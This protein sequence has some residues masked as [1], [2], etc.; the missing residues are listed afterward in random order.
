M[1]RH[2]WKHLPAAVRDAITARLGSLD[3]VDHATAGS[4]GDF[5]ATLDTSTAGRVFCKGA[6]LDTDR[7]GF[8]RNEIRL[9]RHLPADLVPRLRWH[10]EAAGWLIAVFD[11]APGVSVNL[12]PGSPDLP[13]IADALTR[14][15]TVLTPCPPVTIQPATARW[16]RLI[17]PALVD[18]DTLLHTDMTHNNFLICDGR[19]QVVDWSMPCRGAVWLDTARMLVRLI[20]AGHAPAQAESWAARLQAWSSATPEAVDAFA[21]ALAKLSRRLQDNS[22][23]APHLAEMAMA[24]DRWLQ[25][26]L[27]VSR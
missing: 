16:G 7:V 24:S 3:R 18:G 4:V 14:M 10:V 26:R 27:L 20:R 5:A 22:T 9:N 21:A 19:V 13:L 11:H 25:H 17:D 2:L 15:A 12:R 6:Q 8:L 1:A 23:D